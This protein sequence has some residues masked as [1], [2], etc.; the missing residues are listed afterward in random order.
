MTI[1]DD[2]LTWLM[3]LAALACGFSTGVFTCFAYKKLRKEI[4][5]HDKDNDLPT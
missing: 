4:V 2:I 3:V 1:I 5:Q